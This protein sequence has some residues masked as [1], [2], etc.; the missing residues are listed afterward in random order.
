MDRALKAFGAMLLLLTAASAE[1]A[2]ESLDADNDGRL[3]M[4]EVETAAAKVFAALDT[5]M[6]GTTRRSQAGW[7]TGRS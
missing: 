2:I 7:S 6:E 3:D 4:A 1:S 5:G